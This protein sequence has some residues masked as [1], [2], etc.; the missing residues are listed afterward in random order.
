MTATKRF[1]TILILLAAGMLPA[2]PPMNAAIS[3]G[4]LIA[5]P[6]LGI[7]FKTFRDMKPMP[8]ALPGFRAVREDGAKLLSELEWWRFKQSAGVWGSNLA[9]IQLGNVFYAPT[10]GGAAATE[11]E[12]E[13]KYTPLETMLSAEDL[14]KWVEEFSGSKVLGIKDKA[15]SLFGA[16]AVEYDLETPDP[17]VVRIGYLLT[18]GSDRDRRVFVLYDFY[19]TGKREVF[20]KAARQSLGSMTFSIPRKDDKRLQTG[21]GGSPL[22]R[23]RSPEYEASRTRVID[24]IRNFRDWWYMETEN[25]V[26]VSNQ[27]DKRTMLQ[28]RTGLERARSEIY[29][30]YFPQKSEPKAVSV[31]RVFNDRSEY[32]AYIGGDLKWSGALWSPRT[33]ELVISPLDDR[34]PE[35]YQQMVLMQ[36]AFHEGFHQYLHYAV[37]EVM[38][39]M[40]FNEGMAQFFEGIKFRGYRPSIEL[41]ELAKRGIL[42][43][44][45][46]GTPDVAALVKLDR[47]GFYD[48]KSLSGN[49]RL[50]QALCFYLM[51][52]CMVDGNA[53]KYGRVLYNYYDKLL[54]TG[55]ASEAEKAAWDGIDLARLSNDLKQFWNDDKLVRKAERYNPPARDGGK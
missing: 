18:P 21:S 35:V 3:L 19:N 52:G 45:Q 36:N 29:P 20:E 12:L 32:L 4:P 8:L 54:E 43:L 44:F 50:A 33:Q 13:K 1:L 49:Y 27:K 37:G 11:A 30:A 9:R 47:S 39:S 24:N 48:E 6:T 25:F 17:R 42:P 31:V 2:A 14:S 7:R 28:L 10:G 46:S 15:P 34:I 55:E 5:L 51:K 23:N 22:R 53:E 41:P 26:F 38:P 40:W 16:S